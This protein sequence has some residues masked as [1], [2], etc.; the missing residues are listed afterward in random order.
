MAMDPRTTLAGLTALAS[1]FGIVTAS[2]SPVPVS[3]AASKAVRLDQAT[4]IVEVN[5][6]DGD[7]GLQVFLDGEPWRKMTLSAPNGR[8]I[9]A[10]NTG[11]RLRN[12]GLTELFSESSEPSFDEFPLKK[13]KRLFPEGRYR[14]VG[15]T[16]EGQRLVGRARLS[17]DIPDGPE[18]TSPTS[19]ST[20][21]PGTVEASWDPVP[22]PPGIDVVGYRA[23][24]EREDPLRVFSA[25]L[26]A[27]GTS[28][29]IPHEFLESGTE[30]KLEV[31][32][33]EASGNQ[34]LTEITFSVS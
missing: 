34:T 15:M 3:R 10:V 19:G 7:A 17:H 33:I 14:F 18:I 31:Q 21:P 5:A 24:V 16:I 8:R 26:P 13:F 27:S 1:L 11:A 29:T 25:D 32:A 9:L 22:E 12:Y 20:V 6:T 23:I 4:M 30:Y 2:S 28:V